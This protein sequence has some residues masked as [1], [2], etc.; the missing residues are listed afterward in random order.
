[1][2]VLFNFIF[3]FMYDVVKECTIT[4]ITSSRFFSMACFEQI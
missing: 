1:M 3:L 4:F 2:I